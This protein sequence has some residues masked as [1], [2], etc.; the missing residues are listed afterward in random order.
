MKS[1]LG[2]REVYPGIG[3]KDLGGTV[4]EDRTQQSFLAE[5]LVAL[6]GQ[7]QHGV[8]LAPR[9]ERFREV[10]RDSRILRESPRLIADED[11]QP[12]LRILRPNRDIRAIEDV[13]QERFEDAR[14]CL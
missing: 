11:L 7:E 10:R 6:R 2:V 8:V 13:E 12:A 4:V 1:T 9:L 14:I 5:V 3:E